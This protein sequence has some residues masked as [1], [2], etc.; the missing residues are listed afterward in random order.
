MFSVCGNLDLFNLG[1]WEFSP[2][3]PALGYAPAK[4]KPISY[5]VEPQIKFGSIL[6]KEKNI[7]KYNNYNGEPSGAFRDFEK[8]SN[9]V[10]RKKQK[11][12]LT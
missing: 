3:V 9:P 4:F 12:K 2:P 6:N 7:G 5:I 10:N 8:G 1:K 11:K